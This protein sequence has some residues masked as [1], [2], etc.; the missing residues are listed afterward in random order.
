MSFVQ[1]NGNQSGIKVD[2]VCSA[3]PLLWSVSQPILAT[4]QGSTDLIDNLLN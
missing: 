3:I 4:E 1:P 2:A